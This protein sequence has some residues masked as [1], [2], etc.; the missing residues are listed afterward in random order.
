M[1]QVT[2]KIIRW[3]RR[4]LQ[5]LKTSWPGLLALTGLPLLVFSPLIFGKSA[6]W[7]MV[8]LPATAIVAAAA[9]CIY[10]AFS[11]RLV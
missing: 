6:W 2:K 5:V 4:S 8:S 10:L 3:K 9:V 7:I 11:K 1:L